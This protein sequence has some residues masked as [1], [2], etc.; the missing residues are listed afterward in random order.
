MEARLTLSIDK[1]IIEQAKKYARKRNTSISK[2]IENY[3]TKVTVSEK[4][5]ITISPL[6][7]SLSSISHSPAAPSPLSYRHHHRS[8]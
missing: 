7:K 6:V 2:L 1:K 3:L 5:E 8:S 4:E